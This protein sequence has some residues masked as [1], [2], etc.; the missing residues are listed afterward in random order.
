MKDYK[1]KLDQPY[2]ASMTE[3]FLRYAGIGTQ[4][5]RHIEDIPST[6]TQWQLAR[7]L[8]QE[9]KELGLSDVTL[10]EHCYLIAR[11]PATKGL[12]GAPVIGLMAH[13]DTASD[14]P[15]TNVHPKVIHNYD[16]NTL[17]LS[18]SETLDPADYPD[19][20]AHAGDTIITTDGTSLLGADDKA[21][22][23]EIM[24]T[25]EWLTSHPEAK[26]GPI[27]IFFTPDEE[28]G[29]G[30]NL[31]PL[32]KAKSV[33]CYTLDGGKAVEIESEC[34]TAYSVHAEFLGQVIHI[35]AARGKFANAVAMAGHF[36]AML[37]R[38]ESPEA[39]D[40]WYGYYC[41]I[42]I[43]GSMEKTVIDVYL[44]DFTSEGMER[45]IAAMKAF[46]AAV[47]AQFPLGKVQLTVKKQYINMK[48]KLDQTPA[49][50]EKLAEAIRRSGAEPEVKPIRGGTDGSRLTEMG[51]PTPNVFTGGYN[52]H[53]RHEWASVGEMSLAVST[54]I[55]LVA[56]WTE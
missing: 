11:I 38:S 33:A 43:S 37:P 42:E 23:A 16:G 31:F 40:N 22:V 4:S 56:L 17:A 3:R 49:V 21:G 2:V 48:E 45:R 19:L 35:G 8:E 25:I 6:Q 13:M 27:E 28:T 41:P 7:L 52:Y 1:A 18:D 50:L 44:R 46:A 54:L 9:L 30:M 15:G 10:D 36:I 14:V 29:K 24:T 51:I 26:H 53:S 20:A 39:T 47:E 5:D 12:E 34:F 32:A 55:S